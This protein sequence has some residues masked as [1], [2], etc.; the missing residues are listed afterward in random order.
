VKKNWHETDF[1][2]IE[3]MELIQILTTLT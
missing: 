1:D 3:K 2:I